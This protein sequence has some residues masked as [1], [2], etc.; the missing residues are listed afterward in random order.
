MEIY[1][2]HIVLCKVYYDVNEGLKRSMSKVYFVPK[3]K[4][5][6]PNCTWLESKFVRKLC[7]WADIFET[8]GV[9]DPRYHYIPVLKVDRLT[10]AAR[11]AHP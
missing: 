9:R 1:L 10:T 3:P 11:I 4:I 7:S 6:D 8:K 2:L 5:H